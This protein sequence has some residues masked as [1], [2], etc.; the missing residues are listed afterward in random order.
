[1]KIMIAAVTLLTLMAT[2]ASVD[3]AKR[4]L[5]EH[6]KLRAHRKGSDK[7]DSKGGKSQQRPSGAENPTLT[8]PQC[9]EKSKCRS[10]RLPRSTDR[11]IPRNK[12]T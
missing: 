12:E 9:E 1:M 2:E 11:S 8:C 7:E 6:R 3:H 5:R 4:A 10:V